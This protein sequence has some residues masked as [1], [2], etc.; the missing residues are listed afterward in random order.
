M[1]PTSGS[2]AQQFVTVARI[3]GPRGR[4][5]EIAAELLTDFPDRL[6]ERKELFLAGDSAAP[7]RVLLRSFW[8]D[9]NHP[10]RGVLHFEGVDSIDQAEKL[11]GM[12]VRIPWE[13]RAVLPSGSYFV[14]DL[15]GC[16]MFELPAAAPAV[17]SSPCSGEQV[18]E[19]LGQV[20]DV[21]FPGERQ[22]GT[23][24]L[25]VGTASGE[26]LVPL[27]ADIC[28]RVDVAARRIE[29]VLPPGLRELSL[30]DRPA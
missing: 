7:R 29:V 18:P 22:P 19:L 6:K 11:R 30:P 27:A 4:K 1:Q 3:L 16:S 24:L 14:T 28:V 23:P 12:E 9:Q 26:L 15:I 13:E 10:G 25:A 2:F 5:G 17:A 20:R 21:Y 8:V